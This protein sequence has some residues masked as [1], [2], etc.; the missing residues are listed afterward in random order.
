VQSTPSAVRSYGVVPLWIFIFL[1]YGGTEA[2]IA[3][4]L[5]MYTMR[6]GMDGIASSQLI[7]SVF[8]GGLIGG[9]LLMAW[10]IMPGADPFI[11]RLA[12]ITS[13]ASLFWFLA[14]FSSTA[15]LL[16]IGI[17]GICLGP[18]FPLLLSSALRYRL[19]S[20]K[21]GFILAACGVGSAVFLWLLGVLSS[22]SSLRVAMLLP[23]TGLLLLV[24]LAWQTPS[25]NGDSH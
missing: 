7:V 8:W 6:I 22:V 23:L 1:V 14:T 17:T 18:V 12:M 9:R 3:G 2:S 10:L 24:L 5:P 25:I 16:G 4:W 15:L 19:T 20:R 21:M 11:M 13:A